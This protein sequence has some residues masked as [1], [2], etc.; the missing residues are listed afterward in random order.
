MSV[1]MK[2]R[3]SWHLA[4]ELADALR[5]EDRAE[6]LEGRS[7]GGELLHRPVLVAGAGS[8]RGRGCICASGGLV[9]AR[10]ARARARAR[11]AQRRRA[12]GVVLGE[13]DLRPSAMLHVRLE[14]RRP[15][16]ADLEARRRSPRAPRRRP[17]RPSGRRRRARSRPARGAADLAPA[18]SDVAAS[19]A[20]D[21]GRRRTRSSPARGGGARGPAAGRGPTPSP[22]GT[23][24]RRR[25]SRRGGGGSRRSRRSPTAVDPGVEAPSSVAGRRAS[26]SAVGPVALQAHDRRARG[27]GTRPGSRSRR[28]RRTSGSRPPSTRP[29]AGSRRR[30]W[31]DVIVHAVDDAG[32]E[33]VELAARRRPPSPRRAARAPR[34]SRPA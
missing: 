17:A 5:V 21:R 22:A 27:R 12:L 11:R 7:R 23:P 26:S 15:L 24:P 3:A 9:R 2:V 34:R 14:G 16:A 28:A 20:L 4:E 8:R 29:P 31:Q 18:G 19:G 32:R 25:R 33:R 6:P 13:A 10:R 1:N 30:R